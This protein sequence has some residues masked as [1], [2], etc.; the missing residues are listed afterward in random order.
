[1]FFGTSVLGSQVKNLY[2]YL[3]PFNTSITRIVVVV[4]VYRLAVEFTSG[5]N[6]LTLLDI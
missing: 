5:C 6:C 3:H 2:G 1:M 4:F